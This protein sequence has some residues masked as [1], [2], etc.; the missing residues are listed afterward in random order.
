MSGTPSFSGLVVPVV[1]WGKSP[2]RNKITCVRPLS[3]GNVVLTGS[4]DGEVI[5]WDVTEKGELVARMMLIG[6]DASITCLS[7][8]GVT[9]SSTRFVS[10]SS[11]GQL[12]LWDSTDGRSVDSVL[13]PYIHRSITPYCVHGSSPYSCRLYCIGDYAEIIVLDPQ[14]LNTL[15][16]LSSRVEPDWICAISIFLLPGRP[17]S[18]VG[19][20]KNGMMKVWRLVDLDKKDLSSPLYEEESKSVGAIGV[21]SVSWSMKNP[22]ALLV[23]TEKNWQIFDLIDLDMHF[24][25]EMHEVIISG[26]II[27][28]DRVAVA[29]RDSSVKVYLIPKERIVGMDATGTSSEQK[30]VA[31]DS[32]DIKPYAILPPFECNDAWHSNASFYFMTIVSKEV[33]IYM[34]Y[35]AN[36]NGNLSLSV[37]PDPPGASTTRHPLSFTCT[38][39]TSLSEIWSR[40]GR[41]P[42]AIFDSNDSRK[43]TATMYVSSQGR[44]IFGRDDG[45]ILI[46]SACEALARQLLDVPSTD[47]SCRRLFGH[48]AAVSCLLYPHEEHSRYDMQI[49][50]SGS[51]DFSVIVWNINTGSRLYRFCAQGGPILKMLVPPFNCS[52]RVQHTICCIA[53]D[54]SAALLSLKENKCL[55]LASRQ[56]FPIVEVRWRPLDDFMLLRCEDDSVYVWQM[57]TANLERIV[58]GLMSDEVMAACD[59][60]VGVEDGQDEAGASQAIQMLRAVRNKNLSAIRQIAKSGQEEKDSSIVDKEA[61][62]PSPISIQPLSRSADAAHIVLF[63]IDSL[64][65]GLLSSEKEK[66]KEDKNDGKSL[67]SLI[68]GKT[69]VKSLPKIKWKTESD[70]HMDVAYLCM[71]LLHAWMLDS[72]L[73]IVCL[74]KLDLFKPKIPLNF[75]LV[76]RL[77]HISV[78]L[79]QPKNSPEKET[80]EYFAEHIRWSSNS[81]LTTIHLLAIMSVANTLMS[82]KDSTFQKTRRLSPRKSSIHRT[83]SEQREKESQVRQGWSLLTALHCCVL[84]DLIKPKASYCSPRIELLA[85]R[86]QDRCI[87]VRLAAQALLTREMNRLGA[88]G[89]KRLLQV[90]APFLPTLLSPELSIFGSRVLTA[91]MNTAT[92]PVIANAEPPPIPPRSNEHIPLP[93]VQHSVESTESTEAGIQQIRRNQATSIILLGVLGAE[94]PDELNQMDL[95]RATAQSLL[96][97]L[98]APPSAL[99]PFNSPLRRAAID[100]IGRGFCLWQPHLDISKV[101]LGLLDLAA[102]SEKHQV[103]GVAI[104]TSS[105]DACRTARNALNLIATARP[106][107]LIT[108]LSKEVARYNNAAQHQT[109]Q[110]TVVSPLLKSRTEVLRIIELLSEKQYMDVS[111]LIIPVGEILVHCLDTSLLKHRTL[112]EI[113]PPITKFYMVGYCANTRRIAFGGRNGTV[114]VHELR[115]ARSQTIQAHRGGVTAVAFSEDGKYLATYGAEEAKIN[116]WQSSQTFLGMVQSQ[117]KCVRTV[118]APA[119]F[120]VISPGGSPQPFRA[121]LVW[122]SSKSLTLMLPNNKEHRFSMYNAIKS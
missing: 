10:A 29:C 117:L 94:F 113:F 99:L 64:I 66:E 112:S 31:G 102:T 32:L 96:E 13:S 56:V 74:K 118:Q 69:N 80:F 53:G 67:S 81:S 38:T 2:P 77:G 60:Q 73:D 122:I 88:A 12:N 28:I 19:I 86:W 91:A 7:P 95:S 8:T 23:L 59:E 16:T 42:P 58:T 120:P 14:D 101:L 115:A 41:L 111:D 63:D 119:I 107:A 46:L 39:K 17:D 50:V 49:F 90:W 103:D 65:A 121:R 34:V 55:L 85:R 43:I 75:G 105:A 18:V 11:D 26:A 110:H 33:F 5:I 44:L 100:L 87:E 62:L 83:T 70:L 3:K 97:L 40:L 76:S 22:S 79:P 82:L 72:D 61:E 89:R 9:V 71:S 93:E 52:I 104:L 84:P 25:V 6:H 109:I 68:G 35:R 98:I 57:D 54:N 78:M 27:G 15:F 116:F 30:F 37:V 114:V 108:A 92:Q 24:N 45:S 47:I 106:P 36:M 21:Q 20:S 4:A 48:N 1:L 51:L